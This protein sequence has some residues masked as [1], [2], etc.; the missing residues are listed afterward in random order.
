MLNGTTAALLKLVLA[1]ALGVGA[2][3]AAA[4]T[5][6]ET[7]T[8]HDTDILRI[9]RTLERIEGKIDRLDTSSRLRAPNSEV[10]VLRI[11][12]DESGG[13]VTTC[14]AEPASAGPKLDALWKSVKKA[15]HKRTRRPRPSVC[16]MPEPIYIIF[17]DT[18]ATGWLY[19][20]YNPRTNEILAA[21]VT[22]DMTFR[23]V[24]IH[25]MLHAL[26]GPG[27]EHHTERM[28]ALDC[29]ETD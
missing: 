13:A 8:D 6:F 21:F 24:V 2:A 1:F 29:T 18:G 26:Y 15:V 23:C 22:P 10:S 3:V 27:H 20:Y 9:E 7:Q 11:F 25:E 28:A 14:A 16:A 5:T 19:G 12:H 4:Y 17:Q